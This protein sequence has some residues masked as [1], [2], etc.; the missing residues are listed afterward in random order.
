MV[1]DRT[2]NIVFDFLTERRFSLRR[3]ALC[4]VMLI[5]CSFGQVFLM[6]GEQVESLG[7]V[8]YMLGGAL[9]LLYALLL[10][11]NITYLVPRFLLRNKYV[12]YFTLLLYEMDAIDYLLKPIKSGRFTKAV[13]KALSYHKILLSEKIRRKWSRLTTIL[14]LSSPTAG[15]SK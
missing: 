12:E 7:Y 14:S 9:S 11:F 10:H 2:N 8:A 5:G 4:I 13:E 3:K 1:I 15:I 6:F